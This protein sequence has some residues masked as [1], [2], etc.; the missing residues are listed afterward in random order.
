LKTPPSIEEAIS[1]IEKSEDRSL[2]FKAFENSFKGEGPEKISA[3]AGIS[4]ER[5]HEVGIIIDKRGALQ[6]L[7]DIGHTASAVTLKRNLL[8]ERN[9]RRIFKRR[10]PAK[11]GGKNV[12]T[13]FEVNEISGV[14][15]PPE[16]PELPDR[17]P[18]KVK[19]RS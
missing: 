6:Y 12:F 8:T 9:Y 18:D 16:M 5:L 17:N 3:L 19:K 1:R 14:E 2:L 15:N 11:V 4:L 13:Y 7:K 10:G